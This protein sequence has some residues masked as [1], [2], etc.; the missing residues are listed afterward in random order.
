ML[1]KIVKEGKGCYVGVECLGIAKVVNPC[2]LYNSLDDNLDA[3]LSSLISLID[4]DLGGQS[5]F[6]A[7]AVKVRS[8]R[9]DCRVVA[10]R[11]AGWAYKG[12]A[13]VVEVSF[14][15]GNESPEIVDAADK[16]VD[17]LENDR[18]HG[19]GEMDKIVVRRLSIDGEEQHLGCCEG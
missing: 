8:F 11:T 7:N 19:V 5:S 10:C 16:V 1:T 3:T 15:I 6:G 9:V 4:L 18:R 13:V 17:G 12:S 2:V 14:S